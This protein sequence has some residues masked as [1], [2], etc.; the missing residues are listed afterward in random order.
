MGRLML[1]DRCYTGSDNLLMLND[2][3]YSGGRIANLIEKNITVN[4]IYLASEDGA[5]GYSEVTVDATNEIVIF[6]N[7]QWLNPEDVSYTISPT[8]AEYIYIEDG[9]LVYGSSPTGVSV[10]AL[11][12]TKYISLKAEFSIVKAE[13]CFMQTGRC[14]AGADARRCQQDGYQRYSYH[15]HQF[16]AITTDRSITIISNKPREAVFLSGNSTTDAIRIKRL[17][18][19]ILSDLV[20]LN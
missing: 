7:G 9:E 6:E 5:D 4:G 20:D 8:G 12:Q 15:D 16:S 10:V 3:S 14:A 2:E 17:S 13:G 1:N 11:D 19:V 18:V